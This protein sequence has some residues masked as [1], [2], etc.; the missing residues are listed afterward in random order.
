MRSHLYSA[1][2]LQVTVR[3]SPSEVL[4]VLGE[5]TVLKGSWYGEIK[6]EE[7][8]WYIQDGILN[9]QLLKRNRRGSYAN[10][11]NNADTFWKSVRPY[12]CFQFQHDQF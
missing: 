12:S 10:G 9:M 2:L 4:V 6:Q 5:R 8:T 11:S 7:S 3:M 1:T